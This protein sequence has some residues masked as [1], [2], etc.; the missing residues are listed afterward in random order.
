MTIY[1]HNH[2]FSKQVLFIVKVTLILLSTVLFRTLRADETASSRKLPVLP[3]SAWETR[4]AQGS[5]VKLS[6]REGCLAIKYK[7]DVKQLHQVGHVAYK[8]ASFQILL[9]HPVPVNGQESR[10]IFT[11]KGMNLRPRM[12]PSVTLMPLLRDASG[13]L[14]RYY[15]SPVNHLKSGTENWSDWTTRDFYSGEAGGATMDIFEAEGGDGNSWP[16]GK[17][18]LAGFEVQVRLK[19]FGI[20]SGELFLGGMQ[21]CGPLK[22]YEDPYIYAD[23]LL[24]KAGKYNVAMRISEGFQSKPCRELKT[25]IKYDPS[26]LASGKQKVAFPL[27]PDGNYW[28]DYLVTDDKGRVVSG[29]SLRSNV[30]SRHNAP[31]LKKIDMCQIPVLGYLR[32]N[33]DTNTNGVYKSN[34]PMLV[35]VRVFSKGA[36]ELTIDWRLLQY[37]FDTTLEQGKK[38]VKFTGKP[39]IDLPIKL[40]PQAGR[41]AYRLELRVMRG[42]STVDKCEYVLG[43]QTDFSRPY[44]TRQGKLLGRDYVKRSS[45]FRV[46]YHDGNHKYKTEKAVLEHFR[47]FL[48]EASQVTRYMTYMVD[49]ADFEILPGV[50]DFTLLDQLMDEAADRGCALTIRFA[51]A[52]MH[53]KFKWLPYSRQYNYDG[54]PIRGHHAYGGYAFTYKPYLNAWLEA[55]KALYDRYRKHPGFQGYY[56]LKPGGEWT[57]MDRP[58]EGN[59]AGYEPSTQPFFRQY[60]QKQLGLNLKQLNKRWHTS[61]KDWKEVQAPTPTLKMGGKPDTRLAWLDF[62]RF[63]AGLDQWWFEK[64]SKSIREYD[65]NHVVI[66]YHGDPKNLAGPVD[67]LHNGGNHFLNREGNFIDAWKKGLGWI[68][69]PHSPHRWAHYGDPGE[70]G[71][72]LDWSTYVL[73]TQAGGGGANLH[74]YYYPNPTLYLPAHYGGSYGYDRLEKF[75]PIFRE[76]YSTRV[77]LPAAEV[78]VMQD[79]DTLYAKHRTTFDMR[80]EDLGRW[81]ELA[82]MDSLSTA[83]IN[84]K[85]I[86]QFK[87]LLP[88]II[89]EVMSRENIELLEK[90][91]RNGAFMLVAANTGKYCPELGSEKFQLLRRLGINPPTGNY[92]VNGLNVTA[93]AEPGNPLFAAGSKVRFYTLADLK[94]DMQSEKVRKSFWS[95]PYRWIPQTDYFGYY[96]DN[97]QTNGRVLARFAS[98][99]VAMSLHKVGKGQVIVFWGTPEYTLSSLKGMMLRAAKWAGV[100]DPHQG[101]PIPHMIEAHSDKLK[102]HYVLLYQ[103]KLGTYSQPFPETPDGEWF[104]DDMV[105]GQRMG[106]YRGDELRL[107][108]LP[109]TFAEGYSPLKII[110]MTPKNQVL[111]DWVSKYRVPEKAKQ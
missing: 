23:S 38:A 25:E 43:R 52:D 101:A 34:E 48:D 46:T 19:K 8:Q 68:T 29:D 82:K 94:K 74:V 53:G 24:K 37:A 41:D 56:I 7:V 14:L 45:Y 59:I 60:L 30:V 39:Y 89:D 16:D 55:Y 106:L 105:S 31:K 98:N 27:G 79:P 104:L 12:L 61:Y 92:D 64:A 11:A 96:P 42:D 81:L 21:L 44:A 76:L 100:K 32:V 87:L 107:G 99:G 15:P 6:D 65:P 40:T 22:H 91:V 110:R 102:R 86:G 62:C 93:K 1:A 75:K 28:I 67:Y 88:N 84:A 90:G 111:A 97:T 108:K 72:I 20:A 95:W 17:M 50:F 18:V 54:N 103:E 9:K 26:S 57:V 58:W 69:E 66:I 10:V 33:P 2:V 51:H 36:K 80:M 3:V 83:K 49:L 5:V 77:I 109:L 71:W 47:K 4:T 85:N 63:K 70:R 35:T 73:M 78:G 13:E